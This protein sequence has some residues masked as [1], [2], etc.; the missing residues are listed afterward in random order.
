MPSFWYD[1]MK[2]IKNKGNY[3]ADTDRQYF[4]GQAPYNCDVG[5][6]FR[7]YF[8]DSFDLGAMAIKLTN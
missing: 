6:Y 5:A 3:P 1:K 4:R 7:R 2:S 8:P